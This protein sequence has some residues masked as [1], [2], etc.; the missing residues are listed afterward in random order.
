MPATRTIAIGDLEA[1]VTRAIEAAGTSPANALS[2]ARALTAAEVDGQKGHGIWRVPSYAGQ[3]RSGKIKGF[4]VPAATRVRGA[5]L[6]IDAGQGFAFPAL[7]LAVEELARLA[8]QTGIAAAAVTRSSHAGALGLTVERLADRGLVAMAFANT[9]SAMTA[10]GGR[11]GVFGTNPIG[12]AA[13][14]RGAPS[15]VIDL[16][17][18]K[19]ARARIAGAAEKDEP[20]PE[21]WAVDE[22]GQPTTDAKAAMRGFSLPIGDAKGAALAFM[23]EILATAFAGALTAAETTSFLDSQGHSS[24]VGQLLIVLDP[25]GF[26]GAE[27]FAERLETL[28]GMIETDPPARLPGTRRLALREKARRD[29]VAVDVKVLAEA[30]RLAA[31][32]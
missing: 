9:P 17:L 25:A 13:P 32:T 21:G 30:E 1:L 29:G 5:S 8:P 4:A 31:A 27:V 19:V 7:D 15:L 20:I 22:N 11:K 12:F 18:S 16:A 14:R 3:A 2:V 26:A 23:I 28:A 6:L 10:W 24:D